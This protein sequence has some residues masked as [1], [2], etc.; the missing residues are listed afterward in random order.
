M[1]KYLIVAL[2][3]LILIEVSSFQKI[4]RKVDNSSNI[5]AKFGTKMATPTSKELTKDLLPEIGDQKSNTW[6]QIVFDELVR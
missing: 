6:N 1:N 5:L 2:I 4:E 3:G